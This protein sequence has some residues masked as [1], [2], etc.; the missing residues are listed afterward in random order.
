MVQRYVL[1][2]SPKNLRDLELFSTGSA[3]IS[4]RAQDRGNGQGLDKDD[5]RRLESMIDFVR[6]HETIGA[7]TA[8]LPPGTP[9]LVV[10]T[11]DRHCRFLH[12]ALLV[13]PADLDAAVGGLPDFGVT[14]AATAPSVVVRNRVAGR[15]GVPARSIDVRIVQCAVPGTGGAPREV[16]LF[17][18][19]THGSPTFHEVIEDERGH[20]RETHFA[21]GLRSAD[22]VIMGGVHGLLTERGGMVCDGGG[23]NAHLDVTVLYFRDDGDRPGTR[24]HHEAMPWPRR[25]ELMVDGHHPGILRTHLNRTTTEPRPLRRL[26]TRT[27]PPGRCSTYSPGHGSPRR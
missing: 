8:V 25:I 2:S 24:A 5:F 3:P 10:Q 26:R 18:L 23:Y 11:L 15:L 16:E 22:E 9:N 4:K 20:N 17:L 14:P 27:V 1:T 6:S 12:G 7:L 19:P 21:F 13:F